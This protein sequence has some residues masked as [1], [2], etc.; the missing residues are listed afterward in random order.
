[1]WPVLVSLAGPQGSQVVCLP[2]VE[3]DLWY[4]LIF[5]FFLQHYQAINDIQHDIVLRYMQSI[6]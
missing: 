6:D 4:L 5:F 1:M 3:S 2:H